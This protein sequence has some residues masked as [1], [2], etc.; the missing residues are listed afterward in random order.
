MSSDGGGAALHASVARS[1]LS[2]RLLFD[3]LD[4][5]GGDAEIEEALAVGLDRI[6][7]HPGFELAGRAVFRGVGARMAA[8]AIGHALDQRGALA[9]AGAAIGRARGAIDDVGVVAVDDDALEPI[10]CGAVGRRML[11]RGDAGDRRVLHVE[12]VFANKY[13]RQLPHRGEIQGLVEGADIGRAV[14]EEA[15]RDILVALILRAPRG[16]AGDRQMRADDGVGAHHAVL[17]RGEMHRAALAAH[18]AVVALHELAQ[19]LLHRHAARERVR[20]AAIGAEA[21]IAGLHRLG[22]AGGDRLLAEREMAR[23]LDQVLQEEIVGALLAVADLDLQAIELEP[24]RLA[25]IV[26]QAIDRLERRPGLHLASLPIVFVC[27][28]L[29]TIPWQAA[30]VNG[31]APIALRGFFRGSELTWPPRAHISAVPLGLGW[32]LFFDIVD[33]EKGCAGGGA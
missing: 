15:D 10:G 11:D 21:E 3:A 25:D 18:Q 20:M 4:R 17:H 28:L 23:A 2:P 29:L 7:L 31:A 19:H 26:V 6:A 1:S 12:I 24:G 9:G 8:V 13:H 32:R 16:A 14:A 30:S 22:E 27:K 33:R 5:S